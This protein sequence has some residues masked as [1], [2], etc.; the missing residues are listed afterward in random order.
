MFVSEGFSY[1]VPAS[2]HL[3][4]PKQQPDLIAD[5]L[6]CERHLTHLAN[7]VKNTP[8]VSILLGFS[9]DRPTHMGYLRLCLN[10]FRVCPY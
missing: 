10:S 2:L 3:R 6:V 5:I 4:C 7:P 8:I 9:Y 1:L